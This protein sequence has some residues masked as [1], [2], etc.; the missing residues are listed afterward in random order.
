M[1]S[2]EGFHSA[3]LLSL[4]A[5]HSN[6]CI[7]LGWSFSGSSSM[8]CSI[9]SGSTADTCGHLCTAA[10]FFILALQ[11]WW[12]TH[13]FHILA[14][15]PLMGDVKPI[16]WDTSIHATSVL[17]VL[18][19][20]PLQ[21]H[22]MLWKKKTLVMVL[23]HSFFDHTPFRLQNSCNVLQCLC[24]S[25]TMCKWWAEYGCPECCKTLLGWLCC[26]L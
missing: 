17:D 26:S 1:A 12:E 24:L 6:M 5:T 21:F 25:A 13:G 20:G 16:Q 14:T 23:V 9:A 4:I 15:L 2:V 11:F 3:S 7:C 10:G 22:L 19:Y 18:R 8:H